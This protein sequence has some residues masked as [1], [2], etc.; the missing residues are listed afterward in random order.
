MGDVFSLEVIHVIS[1]QLKAACSMV[2]VWNMETFEAS[3]IYEG[4]E[5]KRTFSC[6]VRACTFSRDSTQVASGGDELKI[7]IW[8]RETGKDNIVLECGEA[9]LPWCLRFSHD[10]KRLVSVGEFT[11]GA[12][13]WDLET[14]R[15][16]LTLG[17][18]ER[19]CQ[20]TEFSSSGNFILTSSIDNSA[21]IWDGRSYEYV[22]TVTQPDWVTCATFS[23]NEQLLATCSKDQLVRLW[24]ISNWQKICE[25]AGHESEIRMVS[26][27]PEDKFLAS[28]ALDQTI[29]IWDCDT[30]QQIQVFYAAS[31]IWGLTWHPTESDLLAAGDAVGYL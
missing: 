5:Q 28:G 23:H 2:C 12:I 16:M 6:G 29:C 1:C 15:K 21:R 19:F 25:M 18:H 22:T 26:F 14:Q 17:G 11:N 13:V 9:M 4:H 24:N 10:D 3:L 27:S 31:G 7:R 30:C 20:Y 8:S